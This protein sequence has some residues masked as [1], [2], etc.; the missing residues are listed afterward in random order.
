MAQSILNHS[1]A[2]RAVESLG[3]TV[4]PGVL[5]ALGC[6][7]RKSPPALAAILELGQRVE[8]GCA[9]GV[10][11]A[12]QGEL[13]LHSLVVG[14]FQQA[15]ARLERF[16]AG[17]DVRDALRKSQ[18]AFEAPIEVNGTRFLK[19]S[20]TGEIATVETA[21][22]VQSTQL[23]A[24]LEEQKRQE[25][26]WRRARQQMEEDR[27]KAETLAREMDEEEEKERVKARDRENVK[28]DCQICYDTIK[29][30]EYL[31]L[32]G[33]GHMFHPAC[34]HEYL[35]GEITSRRFPLLCPF[36]NCKVEIREIDLQERL[37]PEMYQKYEEYCFKSYVERNNAELSCCPTPD[38]NFVFIWT[39]EDPHFECPVCK[40]HYCLR[41]RC[42]W[43][44]DM[45]CEQYKQL[46]DPNE[47]DKL[48]ET[49]MKKTNF[50]QC[51]KCQFWVE[52]A[53]G[54]DFIKCRCNF[55]FCYKCG[56]GFKDCTCG[57]GYCEKCG[58]DKVHCNCGYMRQQLFPALANP[59][60][61]K[62]P[63]KRRRR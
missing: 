13:V 29:A 34:I 50:K 9:D 7:Y 28:L 19:N 14:D 21:A 43:H 60:V 24:D 12:A 56:N 45:T 33:C 41:C 22:T 55:A 36:G 4:S 26:D 32:E 63:V 46:K 51:P 62:A 52:R 18:V 11:S 35:E 17:E 31:P 58:H 15:R 6:C 37:T 40:K 25:E 47:L 16:T 48:F 10:L 42:E 54:C 3:G 27:V 53:F 23:Q 20:L 8:K 39:Q 57:Y 59:P 2:L 1:A 30:E 5:F 44:K 49:M 61:R 38:C